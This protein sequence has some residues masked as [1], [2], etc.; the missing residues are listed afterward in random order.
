MEKIGEK[1]DRMHQE[2]MNFLNTQ[3]ERWDNRMNKLGE[4]DEERAK[5]ELEY[6]RDGLAARAMHSLIITHYGE[7][8]NNEE[9]AEKAYEI[10]DVMMKARAIKNND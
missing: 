5:L 9:L 6:V 2:Q 3:E 1:L 4:L 10:A 7:H 8:P